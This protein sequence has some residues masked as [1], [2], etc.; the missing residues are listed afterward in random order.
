M[1]GSFSPVANAASLRSFLAISNQQCRTTDVGA[2][3]TYADKDHHLSSA[4]P[5]N[6]MQHE[7]G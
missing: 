5:H 6:M 2:A 4:A 3:N 1:W 7:L